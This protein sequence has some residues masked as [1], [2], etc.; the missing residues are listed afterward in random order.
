M[1]AFISLCFMKQFSN[2]NL[3]QLLNLFVRMDLFSKKCYFFS[4]KGVFFSAL[5]QYILTYLN[6]LPLTSGYTWLKDEVIITQTLSSSNY[7]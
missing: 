1:P 4:L 7:N 2:E 5:K 3:K 6:L